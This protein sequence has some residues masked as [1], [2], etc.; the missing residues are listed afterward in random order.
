MITS[1]LGTVK[2]IFLDDVSYSH[3]IR[4]FTG[5]VSRAIGGYVTDI[6]LAVAF[7]NGL[8]PT[9]P[10]EHAAWVAVG[11]KRVSRGTMV[12]LPAPTI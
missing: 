8:L 9:A 10:P 3:E 7:S 5:A 6:V 4:R 2:G 1:I 11:R 12:A